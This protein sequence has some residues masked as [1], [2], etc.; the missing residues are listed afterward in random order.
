MLTQKDRKGGGGKTGN[1]TNQWWE[2]F[3][4]DD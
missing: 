1:S 2:K 4:I 3:V